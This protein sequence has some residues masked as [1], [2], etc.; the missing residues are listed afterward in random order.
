MVLQRDRASPI[1]GW[2]DANSAVNITFNG[3]M[4][5]TTADDTGFWR[6]ILPP[7]RGGK[8]AFT[9]SAASG[10]EVISL[11]DVLFGESLLCSGQSNMEFTTNDAANGTA[12]VNAA[13]NFPFIR[14]FSGV[15]QGFNLID[16]DIS[17]SIMIDISTSIYTCTHVH[18]STD[19]HVHI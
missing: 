18:V 7:A 12:E 8:S 15:H 9:I 16:Q 5:T 4:Y 2:A 13:D 17:I 3:A 14:L 11:Q 6:V 10:S 1:I 19:T